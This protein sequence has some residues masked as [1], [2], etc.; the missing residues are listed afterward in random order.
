M[1]AEFAACP[2]CNVKSAAM[3]PSRSVVTNPISPVCAAVLVSVVKP[4]RVY[5]LTSVPTA[6]WLDLVV[7]A[8]LPMAV[9]LMNPA[10]AW[11]PMA[12]AVSALAAA[13]SPT[14]SERTPVALAK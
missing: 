7:V 11:L 4:E 13:A 8:P 1:A 3:L 6:T 2:F 10:L 14:A 12:V 9:E 5:V